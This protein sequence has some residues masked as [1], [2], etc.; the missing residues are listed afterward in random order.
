MNDK[1]QQDFEKAIIE[2]GLTQPDDE[3]DNYHLNL[4][5]LYWLW[6]KAQQAAT[7]HYQPL[8]DALKTQAQ[9]H[10]MEARSSNATLNEIYQLCSGAKGEKASWNGSEPV[11]EVLDAKDAEIAH[12]AEELRSN[13]Q[14]CR[15]QVAALREQN[16]ALKAAL[17]QAREALAFIVYE[18]NDTVVFGETWRKADE[19]LTAIKQ[20]ENEAE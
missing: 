1:T 2:Y 19:T 14:Q 12:K 3:F 11:R 17:E 8:L 9:C 10:A 6:C 15:F 13:D 20:H 7:A 5:N 16:A 4:G 18:N